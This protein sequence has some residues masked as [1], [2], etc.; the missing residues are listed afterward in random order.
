MLKMGYP[1]SCGDLKSTGSVVKK[2]CGS[3]DCRLEIIH[4]CFVVVVHRIR[5]LVSMV[6]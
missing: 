2:M 4:F 6:A 1:G 5:I 3:I